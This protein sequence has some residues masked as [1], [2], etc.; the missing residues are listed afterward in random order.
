MLAQTELQAKKHGCQFAFNRLRGGPD[1]DFYDIQEGT[2]K[3]K[4]K[5]FQGKQMI[6]WNDNPHANG[7]FFKNQM[8][9]AKFKRVFALNKQAKKAGNPLSLFGTN[10]VSPNDIA[11]GDLGNCWILSAAGSMAEVPGRV[12]NIFINHEDTATDGISKNGIYALNLYALMMPIVVTI[13]DRLPQYK[14]VPSERMYTKIGEDG[15]VWGPLLEKA[16][17]YY[18]GTYEAIEGGWPEIA[19]NT[20]AGAPGRTYWHGYNT[21]KSDLWDMLVALPDNAM[22]QSGTSEDR[23]GIVGGHAYTLLRPI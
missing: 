22:L 13:D 20:L 3:Y 18:H 7:N 16:M 2:T 17:A 4:H 15:S 11:Q 10:G 5:E 23:N 6:R 8:K 1:A 12:E 19:L 14:N 21:N 9:Q